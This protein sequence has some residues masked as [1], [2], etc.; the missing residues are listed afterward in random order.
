ME[1]ILIGCPLCILLTLRLSSVS[2]T[3]LSFIS[4][5]AWQDIY[6]Y[7][8]EHIPFE[9]DLRVYGKPPNGV[10]SLLTAS[11]GDNARMRRILDY[12]F[13]DKAYKDLEPIVVGYVGNMIMRLNEQIYDQ[14]LSK[15]G[16]VK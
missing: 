9:K 15:V 6:N 14:N 5:E 8:P 13:S 3:E 1:S 4:S 16:L 12:A 7:H 10:H 11:R 2:P